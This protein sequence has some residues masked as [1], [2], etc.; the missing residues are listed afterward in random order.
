MSNPKYEPGPPS[1]EAIEIARIVD[2]GIRE[3]HGL[4]TAKLCLTPKEAVW[5]VM[6]DAVTINSHGNALDAC[7]LA[8]VAALKTAKLPKYEDG[9]VKYTELTKTGLPLT[10]QNL[11]VTITVHKIGKHLLVDPLPEEECASDARLTM[12]FVADGNI[13]ALQ[14]GG[15]HPISAEE[16]DKMVEIGQ[17][18][19][20]EIRKLLEK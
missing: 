18:K 5:S 6:V 4:D 7:A 2:R 11:P 15:D 17:A 8:A 13:F 12:A 19:A 14:K 20:K 10:A 1:I 16:I 9:V 3:S